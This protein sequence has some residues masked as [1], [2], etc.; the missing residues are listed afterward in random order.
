MVVL[1]HIIQVVILLAAIA[2]L[3]NKNSYE[4]RVIFLFFPFLI[5]TFLVQYGGYYYSVLLKKPNNWIFNLFGIIEYL[6][7]FFFFY[8]VYKAIAVKKIYPVLI[9]AFF[10]WS[11]INL[12]FVQGFFVLNT[13]TDSAA[14]LVTLLS[15]GI[16]FRELLIDKNYVN[17]W[18][19]NV[20]WITIALFIYYIGQFVLIFIFPILF[21]KNPSQSIKFYW[22]LMIPLNLIEYSLFT[23]G[24]YAARKR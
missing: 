18:R 14:C 20:F 22:S 8:N 4:K 24:F 23:I 2:C 15:C 6:F 10:L 13:Y 3:I 1:F 17:V 19:S 16:Y 7:F 5:F 12:F 21:K 11:I 9:I